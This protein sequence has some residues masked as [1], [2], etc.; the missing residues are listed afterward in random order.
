[1]EAMQ[2]MQGPARFIRLCG[3]YSMMIE[4]WVSV[5]P[6]GL[7]LRC[8]ATLPASGVECPADSLRCPERSSVLA[9]PHAGVTQVYIVIHVSTQDKSHIDGL[10]ASQIC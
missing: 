6:A 2:G 3:A 8:P 1:M 9:T 5:M 10:Y 7:L 4:P